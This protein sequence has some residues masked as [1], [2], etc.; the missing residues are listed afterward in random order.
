[1]GECAA[2]A[3]HH[4]RHT[5]RRPLVIPPI[6]IASGRRG[7]RPLYP[8]LGVYRLKTARIYPRKSYRRHIPAGAPEKQGALFCSGCLGPGR[9]ETMAPGG[10]HP[11]EP[12]LN[13]PLRPLCALLVGAGHAFWRRPIPPIRRAARWR[14]SAPPKR[15]FWRRFGV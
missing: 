11:G 1:M 4:M 10:F 9:S 12:R 8:I 3:A 2:D 15:A 7:L 6:Y 14:V 13:I 5:V